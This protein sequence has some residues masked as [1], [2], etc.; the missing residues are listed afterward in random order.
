MINKRLQIDNLQAV[1][2]AMSIR[3]F[4]TAKRSANYLRLKRA[5]YRREAWFN[6][7]VCLRQQPLNRVAFMGFVFAMGGRRQVCVS[8][9]LGSIEY[10]AN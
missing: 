6:V 5:L 10:I 3:T 4:F 8:L 7:T 1:R 2:F 9:A